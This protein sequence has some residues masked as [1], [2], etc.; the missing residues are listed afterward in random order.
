MQ[1]FWIAPVAG[2]YRLFSTSNP[3]HAT[4]FG[5]TDWLLEYSVEIASPMLYEWLDPTP[6]QCYR[7][8]LLEYI[9]SEVDA[10]APGSQVAVSDK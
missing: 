1:L 10:C 2:L 5:G 6:V 3:N 8:Y 7:N 9:V 4:E